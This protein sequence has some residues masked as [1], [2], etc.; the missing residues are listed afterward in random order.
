MIINILFSNFPFTI[1]NCKLT[2]YFECE[3]ASNR[4]KSR[5]KQHTILDIAHVK[6]KFNDKIISDFLI[7]G[8]QHDILHRLQNA[9]FRPLILTIIYVEAGYNLLLPVLE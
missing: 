1:F 8:T 6:Q 3:S 2:F 7:Q 4:S 5:T 9:I